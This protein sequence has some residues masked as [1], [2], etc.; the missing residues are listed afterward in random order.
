MIMR[1]INYPP[2]YPHWG[3][4]DEIIFHLLYLKKMVSPEIL[5]VYVK[6]LNT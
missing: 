1:I 5:K 3:I 6:V 2:P 4:E